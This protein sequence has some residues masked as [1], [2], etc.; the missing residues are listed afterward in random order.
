MTP[1]EL[2]PKEWLAIL[3][4]AHAQAAATGDVAEC[5]YVKLFDPSGR[6]TL[7]V[8]DASVDEDDTRLFGFC[9]S[10]LGADCD[11]WGYASLTEIAATRGR[12]GL[13][14]ERDLHFAGV[15]RA[16]IEEGKRP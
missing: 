10:P 4:S 16:E 8:F 15:T 2:I 11:E 1:E 9:V 6:W 12:F 7:Y 5:A 14:M 13:P 3:Q